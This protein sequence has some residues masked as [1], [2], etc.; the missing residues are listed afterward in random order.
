[1]YGGRFKER[2]LE[3]LCDGETALIF[4]ALLAARGVCR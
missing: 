1:M 4:K 2:Q 3:S